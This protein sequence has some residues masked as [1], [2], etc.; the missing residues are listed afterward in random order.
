MN[1]NTIIADQFNHRVFAIDMN[2]KIVWQ[3]GMTNVAGNT[4]GKLNAPY[5]AF[6]IGDYTGQTR[7]G[8]ESESSAKD[9]AGEN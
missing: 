8:D 4:A 5:T 2:K 3:Y 6:V 9:S 1:K 7:P